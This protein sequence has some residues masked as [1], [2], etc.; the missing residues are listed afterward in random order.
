MDL[1]SGFGQRSEAAKP[2]RVGGV[3]WADWARTVDGGGARSGLGDGPVQRAE[4]ATER[5]EWS[6]WSGACKTG[7]QQQRQQQ[8]RGRGQRRRVQVWAGG[9]FNNEQGRAAVLSDARHGG[10]QRVQ[11][12]GCGSGLD[13]D[14]NMSGSISIRGWP[15]VGRPTSRHGFQLRDRGQDGSQ[16]G[17]SSCGEG[18]EGSWARGRRG[19]RSNCEGMDGRRSQR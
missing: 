5:R 11:K 13:R 3:G 7:Q 12:K 14:R 1:T 4:M 16:A 2:K 8:Q 17:G 9:V 18:L 10:G 19:R 6:M 15:G